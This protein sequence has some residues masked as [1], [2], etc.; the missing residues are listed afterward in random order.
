MRAPW[1]HEKFLRL[2]QFYGKNCKAIPMKLS[3]FVQG[4]ITKRC[5]QFRVITSLRGGVIG[6][7]GEEGFIFFPV[8]VMLE[9]CKFM[10]TYFT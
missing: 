5:T 7:G 6:W 3:A 4:V 1:F 2:F 9:G 10:G 8:K